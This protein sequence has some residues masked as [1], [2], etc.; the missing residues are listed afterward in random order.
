MDERSISESGNV[1]LHKDYIKQMVQTKR[2]SVNP[3]KF[4]CEKYF[5]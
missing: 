5:P 2:S 4:G 3:V 1:N